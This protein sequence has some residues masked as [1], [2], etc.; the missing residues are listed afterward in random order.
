[1]WV[2]LAFPTDATGSMSFTITNLNSYPTA[3][4][5]GVGSGA[6]YYTDSVQVLNGTTVVAP[7]A[8]NL[9][10]YSNGWTAGASANTEGSAS[11]T[12]D[13]PAQGITNRLRSSAPFSSTG[14]PNQNI[15]ISAIV[16]GTYQAPPPP[17]PSLHMFA[18][19][20]FGRQ[21][22]DYVNSSADKCHAAVGSLKHQSA[23]TMFTN[24]YPETS[25]RQLDSITINNC[26]NVGSV[27]DVT[28]SFWSYFNTLTWTNASSDAN[29]GC[30][31]VPTRAGQTRTCNGATYDQYRSMLT[32]SCV[33]TCVV[34]DSNGGLTLKGLEGSCGFLWDSN[35]QVYDTSGTTRSVQERTVNVSSSVTACGT[36][37]TAE[38]GWGM[39]SG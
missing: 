14:N 4:R 28:I 8:T 5:D 11:Y 34:P 29:T 20:A 24:Q 6:N 17:P 12:I 9:A 27:S 30:W 2:T 23:G 7:V 10:T 25:G 21:R 37:L 13:D 31:S 38:R 3:V 15:L 26:T 18:T 36:T 22:L 35:C 19:A 16:C 1:M 33:A 39:M 32:R